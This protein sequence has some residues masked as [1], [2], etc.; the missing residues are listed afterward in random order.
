M[1]LANQDEPIKMNNIFQLRRGLLAE[2][3]EMSEKNSN[4]ALA[5]SGF[6]GRYSSNPNLL[7]FKF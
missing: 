4:N 2:Q 3:P 1:S 6:F 7:N 5:Q